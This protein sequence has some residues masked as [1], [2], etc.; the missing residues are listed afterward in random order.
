MPRSTGYANNFGQPLEGA[1]GVEAQIIVNT[2][3]QLISKFVDCAA[4]IN[5]P[6]NIVS[7]FLGL[8][9]AFIASFVE[10]L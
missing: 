6:E 7:A 10:L 1:P 4:E 8:P 3:Q 2:L 5:C 9:H